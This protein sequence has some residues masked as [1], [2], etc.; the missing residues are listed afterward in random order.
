MYGQAI[1]D[2]NLEVQNYITRNASQFV[3]AG[4]NPATFDIRQLV[5]LVENDDYAIVPQRLLQGHDPFLDEPDY[6]YQFEA[7]DALFAAG[8]VMRYHIKID[9]DEFDEA[10]N[11]WIFDHY[12]KE[13]LLNGR[14]DYYIEVGDVRSLDAFVERGWV[15]IDQ[16]LQFAR[17][18]YHNNAVLEE[19]EQHY[20]MYT[21]MDTNEGV[22][23]TDE[24]LGL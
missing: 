12:S 3:P 5:S 24:E 17:T 2:Q 15:T 23:A 14:L 8:V 21:A 20:R 18:Y 9:Y 19:L 22:M 16:I 6:P 13:E 11:Q 10:T 1:L 7:L 4:M